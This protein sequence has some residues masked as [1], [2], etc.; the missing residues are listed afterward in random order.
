MKE[1]VIPMN[2][3]PCIHAAKLFRVSSTE[4]ILSRKIFPLRF[5]SEVFS[6]KICTVKTRTLPACVDTVT[7]STA[8]IKMIKL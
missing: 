3:V 4:Q 5:A 7:A 6:L 1:K 2:T 8:K